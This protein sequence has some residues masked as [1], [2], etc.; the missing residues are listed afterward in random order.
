MPIYTNRTQTEKYWKK[1]IKFKEFEGNKKEMEIMD[2]KIKNAITNNVLIKTN[3]KSLKWCN[4]YRLVPKSNRDYWLVMDMRGVN[5]FMKPIHFKMENTPTLKQLLMKNNFAISYDLKK[6]YNHI[7]I[8]PTM[9]DLLKIQYQGRLYKY[10]RMPFCLNNTP[11]VLFTQIMKKAIHAIR[12]IWKVRC[13]IYLD[14]LLVL[15]QDPHRLIKTYSS[16]GSR[17]HRKCLKTKLVKH[18]RAHSS[19][20]A[21][22]SSTES[23]KKK[24]K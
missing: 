11:R 24:E 12:K 10:Q 13:V 2:K 4:Q 19:T 21:D 9:Q 18:K 14:N 15:H 22:P 5:Q 23:F 6:T 8:H 16:K 7:P 1:N 17:Q 20:S 3:K